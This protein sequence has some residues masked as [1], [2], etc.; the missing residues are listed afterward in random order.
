MLVVVVEHDA[1]ERTGSV[2]IGPVI[3]QILCE[4][5]LTAKCR[6]TLIGFADG[7]IVKN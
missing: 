2:L 4:L 3:S 6:D 7:N 5:V 1:I